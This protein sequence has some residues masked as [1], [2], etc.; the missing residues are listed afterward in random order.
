MPPAPAPAVNESDASAAR[1]IVEQFGLRLKDVSLLAPNAGESIRAKYAGLVDERLL[2]QWVATPA[3]APGRQVS[4]P[5]PDRIEVTDVSENT[6]RARINGSIVEVTSTGEAG[7]LPV[8]ITLEKSNAGW[9]ITEYQAATEPQTADDVTD[10]PASAI[11]VVKSYYEAIDARD[12]DRAWSFWGE[13]GAPGQTRAKFEEGFA[14][15]RGV[16]VTTGEPSRIEAAA[17]SRYVEIP[18]VIVAQTTDG[19]EQFKGSYTL[20]RSVVDGA[21]AA[22]RR[23]H[24]YRATIEKVR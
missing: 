19:M 6:G 14:R 1:A 17:G 5:W 12:F 10:T 18:V 8:R 16:M 4:S 3:I 23:W 9:R 24:L 21:T 15:T 20:R 11:A 7:R 13:T 22:Q 2:E